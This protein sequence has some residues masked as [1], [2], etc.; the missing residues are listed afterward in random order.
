MSLLK[1]KINATRYWLMVMPLTI[2]FG[3]FSSC[4]SVM[5]NSKVNAL[6]DDYCA[7]AV[8]Y[9][10]EDTLAGNENN[11]VNPIVAGKLNTHDYNLA[12]RIGLTPL[13]ADYLNSASPTD[14]LAAKQ[15]LTDKIILFNT[16]VEAVV[17]ELDCNG[18]RFDQ[19]A[20]FIHDKMAV[21]L[22]V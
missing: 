19:L 12:S 21:P 3:L 2:I 16:Q 14:K 10:Q 17:A 18:E 20:R 13:I 6:R 7:P 8:Q 9:Q 4:S 1:A 22:P 11:T 15:K 5:E